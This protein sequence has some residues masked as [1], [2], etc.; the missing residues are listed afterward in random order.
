VRWHRA[1]APH[2]EPV[3]QD[4][5]AA[6]EPDAGH[7]VGGDLGGVG[8]AVDVG[9]Q[10]EQGRA[11]RDQCVGPQPGPAGAPLPLGADQGAQPRPTASR[12]TNSSVLSVCIRARSFFSKPRCPAAD[13]YAPRRTDPR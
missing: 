12:A 8:A 11:G 1:Q 4:H 7:H 13:D 6:E 2:V 3:P 5:P 10:D 9:V